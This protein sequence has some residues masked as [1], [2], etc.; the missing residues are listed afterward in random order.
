MFNRKTSAPC[1]INCRSVSG[2]S[3]AGPSVQ[4]IFVLRMVPVSL[5]PSFS[6][7]QF[8]E[9]ATLA[10][11]P[12]SKQRSGAPCPDA[13]P[14]SK[15]CELLQFALGF[16]SDLQ[17]RADHL[18]AFG[19]ERFHVRVGAVLSFLLELGQVLLMI[20]HHVVHVI[21]VRFPFAWRF[22]CWK[23]NAFFFGQRHQF[24]ICL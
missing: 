24:V 23:R 6:P 13:P 17:M 10:V 2:F 5:T 1:A 20:L 7:V 9:S 12:A 11:L 4:I 14:P 8:R 3:V 18:R 15:N 21:L 19:C 16:L 22:G